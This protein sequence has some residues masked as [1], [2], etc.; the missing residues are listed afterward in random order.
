MKFSGGFQRALNGSPSY[1]PGIVR[2]L[3]PHAHEQRVG[4]VDGHAPARRRNR[5]AA[6]S[7]LEIAAAAAAAAYA[8]HQQVVLAVVELSGFVR[9]PVSLVH[10]PPL[11]FLE[12]QIGLAAPDVR[13]GPAVGEARM[14]RVE[15]VLHA[16]QPVAVLQALHR[17]VELPV[18]DEKVVPGQKRCGLGPEIREH[19]P[20]QLLHRIGKLAD[21]V[22]EFAFRRL[23]GGLENA[24][25][26]VVQPT[27]IPAA[28]AARLHVPQTQV[29]APVRA[30]GS[31]HPRPALAVP[32][33]HQV[34]A[35]HPDERG[36]VLQVRRDTDRPPV[37]PQQ[38][39]HG[40]AA[41]DLGENRVLL[42]R[43]HLHDEPPPCRFRSSSRSIPL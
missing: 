40:R 42:L 14:H 6:G 20:P 27:V 15:A 21:T 18:A 12:P 23:A 16:L 39:P 26:G 2:G 24:A 31:Q 28:Q 11:R 1:F 32:E 22:L 35:H 9:L 37:T 7:T 29:R 43:R 10:Q 5:G 33:Q 30:V 8:G 34:L 38:L 13:P 17:H 4:I 3:E 36:L 41:P 19:E 25:F